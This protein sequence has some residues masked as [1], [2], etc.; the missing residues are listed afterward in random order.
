MLVNM[1]ECRGT[2]DAYFFERFVGPSRSGG[3]MGGFLKWGYLQ[4]SSI[5]FSIRTI[6]FGVSPYM[7]TPWNPFLGEVTGIH[8]IYWYLVG[9]FKFIYPMTSRL[10]TGCISSWLLRWLLG[11]I[12]TWM[13]QGFVG[14][15]S[16]LV[17]WGT[18]GRWW[19][20]LYLA[21]SQHFSRS[22]SSNPAA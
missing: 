14:Q 22:N 8:P 7:E 17:V 16:S 2:S 18:S 13:A 21:G 1:F 19:L 4:S 20:L 11:W 10:F 6:Y 12:P 5:G 15:R 3:E 9:G